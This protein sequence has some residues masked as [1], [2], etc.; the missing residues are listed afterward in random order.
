[1]AVVEYWCAPDGAVGAASGDPSGS[2]WLAFSVSLLPDLKNSQGL[3]L[4]LGLGLW[5]GWLDSHLR[6]DGHQR[7][8]VV[9]SGGAS[10]PC[11]AGF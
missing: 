9:A 4:G 3:V 6:L 7:V 10:E 5:L 11:L 1:M 8:G 2:W